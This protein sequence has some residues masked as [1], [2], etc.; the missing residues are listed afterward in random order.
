M[1]NSEN[2]T[3]LEYSFETAFDEMRKVKAAIHR[4]IFGQ[5][6]LIE[7]ML[8]ALFGRVHALLEGVPGV[9]KTLAVRTLAN[10]IDVPFRRIQ[11]TPDLLPFDLTGTVTLEGRGEA[12][13]RWKFQPGPIFANLVLADEINR[14]PPKTQVAL[15]EAMGSGTVTSAGEVHELPDPFCVFATQNPVEYLGTFELS[16]LQ[17]DRFALIIPVPYP[18]ADAE[19]LV[20]NR[21]APPRAEDAPR[22]LDKERVKALQE[23]R[24]S[25]IMTESMLLKASFAVSCTRPENEESPE[26]V[27]QNVLYGASPRATEHLAILCQVRAIMRGRS[28]V[29]DEDVDYLLPLVVSHRLTMHP[30]A[31]ASK[32]KPE[33]VASEILEHIERRRLKSS[34]EAIVKRVLV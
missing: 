20:V 23:L 9:A 26:F 27:K 7:G 6:E 16:A 1:E 33:H 19:L 34:G 11:L 31:I 10:V 32:V 28:Y 12:H 30:R 5:E 29:V 15:L 14:T 3:P 24:K 4:T 2:N 13:R 25:V 17:R 21:D 22:T 8:L 18:D